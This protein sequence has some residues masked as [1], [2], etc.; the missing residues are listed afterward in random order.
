[1]VLNIKKMKKINFIKVIIKLECLFYQN[2]Y[3]LFNLF[4]IRRPISTQTNPKSGLG[5]KKL[6]I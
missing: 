6:A 4:Y 5:E 2:M 1:M 3:I